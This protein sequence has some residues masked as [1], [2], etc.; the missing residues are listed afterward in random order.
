MAAIPPRDPDSRSGNQD[1]E[2][3]PEEYH[4]LLSGDFDESS[5]PKSN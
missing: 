4:P 3:A 2:G 1:H 5:N